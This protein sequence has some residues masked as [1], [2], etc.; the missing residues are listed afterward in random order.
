MTRIFRYILRNDTG[1]APCTD[2]GLV[3]L[4]TCKPKIRGRGNLAIGLS[5]FT[6]EGAARTRGLGGPYL[7]SR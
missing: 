5:A 6:P 3:S 4:A 1:M 7:L 2:R